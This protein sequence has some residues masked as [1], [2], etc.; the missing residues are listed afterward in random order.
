MSHIFQEFKKL[1]QKD[2]QNIHQMEKSVDHTQIKA[3]KL[4]DE[5]RTTVVSF[6]HKTSFPWWKFTC[7]PV[8]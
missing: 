6:Q 8:D 1:Q 7:L 4:S 2:M 5:I 3:R